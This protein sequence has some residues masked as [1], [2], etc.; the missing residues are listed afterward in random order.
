MTKD[1]IERTGLP[2]HRI[3]IKNINFL[4]DVAYVNIFYYAKN[5]ENT[6]GVTGDDD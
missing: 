3:E 4:R 1:L 2:I 5:N 6:Q